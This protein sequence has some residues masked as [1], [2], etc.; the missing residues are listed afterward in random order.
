MAAKTSWHRY[1]TKLGHCHRMYN[2]GFEVIWSARARVCTDCSGERITRQQRSSVRQ[3]PPAR[4]LSVGALQPPLRRPC[5]CP[6]PP[7]S[8]S[9]RL[10]VSA[11]SCRRRRRRLLVQAA[12]R[13]RHGAG[14]GAI[15]SICGG[16]RAAPSA[17]RPSRQPPLNTVRLMV[18]DS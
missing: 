6:G 9:G 3:V 14:A 13:P 11:W 16:I 7:V 4:S 18:T 5:A 17:T 1:G 2:K 8:A 10:D 15:S 12:R